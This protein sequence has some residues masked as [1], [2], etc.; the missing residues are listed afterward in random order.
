MIDQYAQREDLGSA[1]GK[2]RF[3]SA[4]LT[5]LRSMN[6]VVETE[7]YLGRIADLTNTS[8]EAIKQKFS[9]TGSEEKPLKRVIAA[10]TESQPNKQTAA[11]QDDALAVLLTV[12]ATRNL[13][14]QFSIELF[15]GEERQM[16]AAYLK[17]TMLGAEKPSELQKIETYVKIVELKAET[18]Y[19]GWTESDVRLEAAR[20][21]RRMEVEHKKR[22]TDTL[23]EKLREA[24]A[25]G[26]ESLA[27]EL[28]AKVH[29]LIKETGRG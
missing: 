16:L 29:A 26:D 18:R 17:R 25:N 9:G 6:D 20:L 19:Q 23:V 22:T 14:E 13:L 8:I 4:S 2:R 1:A 21:L 24:E 10:N 3:T 12:P 7:H 5:V 15:E 11:Y 28:R 27:A